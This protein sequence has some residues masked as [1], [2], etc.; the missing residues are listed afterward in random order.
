VGRAQRSG[1]GDDLRGSAGAGQASKYAFSSLA[2]GD[3]KLYRGEPAA[4]S[5]VPIA[6]GGAMKG[7][8]RTFL[9]DASTA[10]DPWIDGA[11]PGSLV[12][13]VPE[14]PLE[15]GQLYTLVADVQPASRR[16][17]GHR[18]PVHGDVPGDRLDPPTPRA[19]GRRERV[20][21]TTGSSIRRRSARFGAR[22]AGAGVC[23]RADPA[24]R[25]DAGRRAAG[26]EPVD[27]GQAD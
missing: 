27:R 3:V 9:T 8:A 10:R 24:R 17:F 5:A 1:A 7:Y 12:G 2:E 4:D 21:Q 22:R 25:F 23:L 19:D 13:V 15:F 16:W 20:L 26:G 18:A 11:Y 14:Q 6:A